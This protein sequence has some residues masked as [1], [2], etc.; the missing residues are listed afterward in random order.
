MPFSRDH[1]QCMVESLGRYILPIRLKKQAKSGKNVMSYLEQ[2]IVEQYQSE[3]R[4]RAEQERKAQQYHTENA[5]NQ[6]RKVRRT[7]GRVLIQLG[8]SLQAEDVSIQTT[9]RREA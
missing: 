8:E 5:Q 7:I 3:M 9:R 4:S 6:K 1:T 2:R